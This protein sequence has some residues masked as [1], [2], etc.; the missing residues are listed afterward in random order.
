MFIREL[1]SARQ[2]QLGEKLRQI[3]SIFVFLSVLGEY[4]TYMTVLTVG[5]KL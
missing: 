5:I 3:V 1:P 2:N 4:Q